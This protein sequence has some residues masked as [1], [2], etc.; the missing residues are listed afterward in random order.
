MNLVLNTVQSRQHLRRAGKIRI[1]C[2]IRG[3]E[4][5]SDRFRIGRVGR[6]PDGGTTISCAI[7]KVHRRFVAWNQPLEAVGRRVRD[8][9][10]CPRVL[11]NS[12]DVVESEFAQVGV[13]LPGKER[14]AI[15]PD[16]LVTVHP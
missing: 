4:L 13:P 2:G 15:F 11:D 6:N 5:D 1:G 10:Q 14:L 8:G 3:A 7:G 9:S 12:A 16:A